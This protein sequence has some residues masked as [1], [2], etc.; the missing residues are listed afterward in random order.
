MINNGNSTCLA[1][2][3]LTQHLTMKFVVMLMFVMLVM[4]PESWSSS[5]VMHFQPAGEVRTDPLM[6]S[7]TGHCL[8]DHVHRFFGAVSDK[9]LRPEVTWDDLRAAPDNS[10]DVVENKSL[11][12]N[13]VL[14]KVLNPG[15]A[16][17]TFQ[18]VPVSHAS[19]YYLFRKGQATA[20]PKGFKMKMSGAWL[21]KQP[22]IRRV[23]GE[24]SGPVECKRTDVNG[25]QAYA[26][27]NQTEAGMLPLTGCEEEFFLELIFPQCWDGVNLESTDQSHVAYVPECD[28][29]YLCFMYNCPAS[30][31]VKL[32]EI[33]LFLE[34]KG[35]VYEGGAHTFADGTAVSNSLF[36]LKSK[37]KYF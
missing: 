7:Q 35:G 1:S 16:D 33:N 25:C 15:T 14:Y 3:L 18:F 20:F 26:P 5:F 11:Y 28:D 19:I 10:G 17:E 4:I 8:S 36:L 32:P 24:C 13:P 30:H 6:F 12:W 29:E 31:P 9:S 22:A 23:G 34:I 37:I 27:A 2:V 21:D